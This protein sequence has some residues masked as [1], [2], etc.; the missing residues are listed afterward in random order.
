VPADDGLFISLGYLL[1][2]VFYCFRLV[3]NC[4]YSSRASVEVGLGCPP[5]GDYSGS[6]FSLLCVPI[7]VSASARGANGCKKRPNRCIPCTRCP[8]LLTG[9]LAGCRRPHGGRPAADPVL[10]GALRSGLV[11]PC[12]RA[13]VPRPGVAASHPGEVASRPARATPRPG[14]AIPRPRLAAPCSLGGIP[15]W[16][17]GGANEPKRGASHTEAGGGAVLRATPHSAAAEAA[18]AEAAAA[19]VAAAPSASCAA[20]SSTNRRRARTALGAMLS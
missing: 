4:L 5:R 6:F 16:G 9:R 1:I 17:L 7:C 8:P 18:P 2:V 15:T 10:D 12:P 14:L 11:V 20:L 13:A 19:A 3:F